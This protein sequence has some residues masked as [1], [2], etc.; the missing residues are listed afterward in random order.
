MAFSC[1]SIGVFLAR[2]GYREKS[3]TELQADIHLQADIN[4]Q[5][6]NAKQKQNQM[7]ACLQLNTYEGKLAMSSD[8]GWLLA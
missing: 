3:S 6:N 5:A 8:V 2:V 4:L 7:S 1:L